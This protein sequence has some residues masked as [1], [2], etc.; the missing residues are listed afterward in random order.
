[1]V[2]LTPWM[3][4]MAARSFTGHML[5]HVLMIS[6][7]APL[8]VLARPL[9][10][11]MPFGSLPSRFRRPV[12]AVSRAWHRTTAIVAPALFVTTLVATHLTGIYEAALQRRWVHDLEH[13][14]YLLGALALW[15]LMLARG[16]RRGP[17]RVVAVFAVIA[18]MALLGA[19]LLTADQALIDTYA[20]RQGERGALEDQQIAASIMWV[21]GMLM[22]VPL[23]VV[24]VW[25]WAILE[26]LTAE[27]RE[28]LESSKTPR[29]PR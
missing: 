17:D 27:R 4:T 16:R 8:V 1:M 10:T 21:T 11:M 25:R 12:H 18:G 7:G 9:A 22:T 14:A 24:T 6:V 26:Q 28:S 19:V 15:A 3:E 5:Q 29:P 20:D 23:L 2:S 13:V